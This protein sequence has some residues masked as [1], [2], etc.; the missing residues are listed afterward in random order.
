MRG[1][2][3]GLGECV[4]LLPDG[5]T[6]SHWAHCF[7]DV[8]LRYW[9]LSDQPTGFEFPPWSP[10]AAD[11]TWVSSSDTAFP[12]A[13]NNEPAFFSRMPNERYAAALGSQLNLDSR[14]FDVFC[15]EKT[16]VTPVVERPREAL[17]LVRAD[18]EGK[19]RKPEVPQLP[20]KCPSADCPRSFKRKGD[21]NRHFTRHIAVATIFVC[22]IEECPRQDAN[23]A[24]PRKDKL[25]DHVVA[26]HKIPRSEVGAVIN[27][28]WTRSGDE[29]HKCPMK[30]CQQ[31]FTAGRSELRSLESSVHLVNVHGASQDEA[32]C[33]TGHDTS[34]DP[35]RLHNR[36]KWGWLTTRSE[37]GLCHSTTI[38]PEY[39]GGWN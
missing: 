5:T 16:L 38:R 26:A 25:M 3:P 7:G 2:F 37:Q 9:Q 14:P 4:G 15:P 1:S 13:T 8:G 23:V 10:S 6:S 33:F 29:Y 19:L 27:L 31:I 36:C 20:Y 32:Y 18:A 11:S 34:T 21:R 24:F 30:H 17:V 28:P 39:L 12:A 35:A 22:P